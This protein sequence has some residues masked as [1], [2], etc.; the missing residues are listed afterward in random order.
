MGTHARCRPNSI[1]ATLSSTST[2]ATLPTV[3]SNLSLRWLST[4]TLSQAA[5]NL[6]LSRVSWTFMFF[7]MWLAARYCPCCHCR[8]SSC[9]CCCPCCF[10]RCC[11]SSSFCSPSWRCLRLS[12]HPSAS[13]AKSPSACSTPMEASKG[14]NTVQHACS[15]ASVDCVFKLA[16]RS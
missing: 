9:C 14:A 3:P 7:L 5:T 10:C 4:S 16:Q 1:Q 12:L 15:H 8:S 11:S 13:A 2:L 6:N